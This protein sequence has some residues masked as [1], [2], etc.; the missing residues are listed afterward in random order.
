[1]K[2]IRTERLY[3]PNVYPFNQKLD[4]TKAKNWLNE[5]WDSDKKIRV[6]ILPHT[7]DI[8]HYFLP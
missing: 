5:G 7:T 2:V 6:N 1:M 8:G 3:N 4:T